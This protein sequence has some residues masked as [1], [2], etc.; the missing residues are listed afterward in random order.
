MTVTTGAD[1]VIYLDHQATTPVDPRVLEE[2]LPYLTSAYGKLGL[3][4]RSELARL[5][6]VEPGRAVLATT[7]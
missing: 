2:M 4:S 1:D 5:F 7:R 6:A 3:R